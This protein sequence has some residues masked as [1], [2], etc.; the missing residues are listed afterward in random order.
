MSVV[1]S[2]IEGTAAD[3]FP[4]SPP[5][6][7]IHDHEL[8]L[9]DGSTGNAVLGVGMAGRGHWSGSHSI[10]LVG[11]RRVVRGDLACLVKSADANATLD[12][13]SLGSTYLVDPDWDILPNTDGIDP[14]KDRKLILQRGDCRI[15]VLASPLCQISVSTGDEGSL[16]MLRPSS[17]S[18]E[19]NV[20]TRW[21]FDIG[22]L[23]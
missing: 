23:E 22:L 12:S 4:P 11:K 15:Q 18:T 17:I 16:L 7:D 21:K 19:T 20:A 3:E 5:M 1:M 9:S 14:P 8:P 10:E 13:S 6:Q 2:S